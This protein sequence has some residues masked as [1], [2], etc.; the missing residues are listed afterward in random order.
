MKKSLLFA[1]LL[2][3][4]GATAPVNAAEMNAQLAEL[5]EQQ[6]ADWLDDP[7]LMAA[8]AT[9]NAAHS[10][11]SQ[12][13]IDTLD[14]TW[15]AEISS[16]DTPLID[17]VLGRAA[18]D[19]L[20]D[21]KDETDGLI[22]EVFLMDN[23]G[24]NVAQS[25]LTS[26]YWQ[27]DEAKFQETYGKGA[28]SIHISEVELDESTGTYQSQVSMVVTDPASGAPMGAITFGVNVDYLN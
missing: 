27:G 9:Q 21:R 13:D 24:L 1:M 20:R 7:G 5:A 15:R 23:R 3:F 8:L 14:R 11:L 6:F 22:T 2:A 17:D 19:Y 10:G 25:D 18:S 12:T 16:A 4:T 28:G 26:D